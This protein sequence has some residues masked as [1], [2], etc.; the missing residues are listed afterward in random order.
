MIQSFY[1]IKKCKQIK[2][3]W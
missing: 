2:R 1:D 3:K